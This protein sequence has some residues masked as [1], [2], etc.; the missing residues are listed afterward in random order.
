MGFRRVAFG[1]V[2]CISISL[3]VFHRLRSAKRAKREG[4]L[5][6]TDLRL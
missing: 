3:L 5:G 6:F 1:S 4:E 2:V